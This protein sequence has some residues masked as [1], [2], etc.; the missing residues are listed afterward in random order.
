MVERIERNE[1][2]VE[3]LS[4]ITSTLVPE[5]EN[6]FYK[7]FRRLHEKYKRG[8]ELSTPEMSLVVLCVYLESEEDKRA[9]MLFTVKNA[10]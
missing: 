10:A 6:D 3:L 8:Q 9:Q 2:D 7:A 5:D 1:R 4:V